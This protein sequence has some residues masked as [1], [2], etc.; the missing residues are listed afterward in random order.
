MGQKV[1]PYSVRLG[2]TNNWRSQWFPPK[3]QFAKY[4]LQDQK[5]REYLKKKIARDGAIGSIEIKRDADQAT[6][7]IQTAKPGMVIGRAGQG[8]EELK[9]QIAKFFGPDIKVKIDVHEIK[10]GDLWAGVVAHNI[11][12]QIERR[13]NFRR[14]IKQAIERTMGRGAKGIRVSIA[15]RLNG[16]EIARSE[17]FSQGTVPLSTFRADIDY[18]AV[19]AMTTYGVTGIKVWICKGEKNQPDEQ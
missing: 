4:L 14:A 8:V 6:V 9:R 1:N 3:G 19:D 15:G 17:N 5:V 13:I 10:N 7:T 12:S 11:A 18:A 16:A 2:I